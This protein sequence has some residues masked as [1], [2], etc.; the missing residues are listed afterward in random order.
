MWSTRT[1]RGLVLRILSAVRAAVAGH[2]GSGGLITA[3]PFRC[4]GLGAALLR[5]KG[6]RR[7]SHS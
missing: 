6:R 4:F 5:L 2:A 7:F 3:G 1:I